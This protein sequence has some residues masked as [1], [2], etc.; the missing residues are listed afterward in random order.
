VDPDLGR[1]PR[2]REGAQVEERKKEGGKGKEDRERRKGRDMRGKGT[3]YHTGT[4]FSHFRPCVR[5][6]VA[7]AAEV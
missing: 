7:D 5:R 4:S 3:A 2:D 6:S 1:E